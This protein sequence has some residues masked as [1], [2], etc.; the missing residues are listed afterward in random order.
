M[1]SCRPGALRGRRA[2][3]F[4]LLAEKSV[5]VGGQAVIEGVLMRLPESY[6]VAVR[7]PRGTVQV[8]K[9]R[10]PEAA[11]G[12]LG[13]L[14][15]VRG[16][17]ILFRALLLGISALN[18]SAEVAMSEEE[19]TGKSGPA[20]TLSLVLTVVLSLAAGVLLFFY[21]PLFAT[22]LISRHWGLAQ[23][24][25]GFNLVDG[26]LRVAVFLLYILAISLAKDIRRVFAYHGAE[27]KAV[28]T[29]E[30]QEALTVENARRHP[31]LHPRCG[32]SFLLFVMVVSILVFALVPHAAPFWVKALV[33]LLFLPLI[34]GISY[35][36][37]RFTAKFPRSPWVKPLL[38]PGLAFQLL[39]TREPDDAMLEVALR[40]LTEARDL[41]PEAP[42]A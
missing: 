27:H 2:S 41:G 5:L 28:F 8:K 26:A 22:E 42:V 23:T 13:N 11:R 36:L 16:S 15:L 25:L 9:D 31:R 7:D 24:S 17:V 40:A 14:P 4:A 32:T 37:I 30:A 21:L 10:L 20:S 19:G 34:A 35:E 33:R 6:A 1:V 18:Y 38:W 29:W 3:V 39:T 12:R